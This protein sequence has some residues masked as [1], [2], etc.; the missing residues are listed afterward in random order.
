MVLFFDRI[1][2][3]YMI[4]VG[5]KGQTWFANDKQKAA[6]DWRRSGQQSAATQSYALTSGVEMGLRLVQGFLVFALGGGGEGG[7]AGELAAGDE[8]KHDFGGDENY[9]NLTCHKQKTAAK[10]PR[11]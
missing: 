3:I 10:M 5:K 11:F 2:K 6:G 9:K 7:E 1:N 8:P 4:E